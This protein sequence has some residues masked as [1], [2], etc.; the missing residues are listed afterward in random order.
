MKPTDKALIFPFVYSI[1][2]HFFMLG[3]RPAGCML[4]V[5]S[6]TNDNGTL[7]CKN[8]I[9]AQPASVRLSD[10][11]FVL[12]CLAYNMVNVVGMIYE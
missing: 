6:A 7:P 12:S 11:T 9:L 3:T 1:Q 10:L 2:M 5:K 4:P 8:K